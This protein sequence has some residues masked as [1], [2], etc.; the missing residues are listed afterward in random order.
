[1]QS[2]RVE[3]MDYPRYHNY[4]RS[5]DYEYYDDN[6][7]ADNDD[8]RKIDRRYTHAEG[9]EPPRA[10]RQG[11]RRSETMTSWIQRQ[12][13]SHGVQLAGAAVLSGVAVAGAILGYQS[14]KRQAAVEE[15][16]ASIPALDESSVEKVG[17]PWGGWAVD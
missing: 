2:A 5:Q 6:P 9:S 16:K 7:W 1:M 11:G 3:A 17:N 8:K 14:V 4:S 13:S 15:L 10:A 12:A